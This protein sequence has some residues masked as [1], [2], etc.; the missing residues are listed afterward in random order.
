MVQLAAYGHPMRQ[1]RDFN[2]EPFE[3]LRVR[4]GLHTGEVEP[5]DDDYF[6]PVVNR[7]ARVM[8]VANGDQ[9]AVSAATQ[10][11]T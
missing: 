4:M 3:P 5:R 6:G 9:I 2:P 8:A 7:A 10:A 1:A 11:S